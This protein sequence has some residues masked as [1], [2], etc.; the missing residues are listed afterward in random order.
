[1][2][3]ILSF[4]CALKRKLDPLVFEIKGEFY[5]EF[6]VLLMIGFGQRERLW[7]S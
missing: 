6:E 7:T 2:T 1:M 4:G 3:L 5:I